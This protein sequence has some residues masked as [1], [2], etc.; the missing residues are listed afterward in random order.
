MEQV[1]QVQ[2]SQAIVTNE[3]LKCDAALS[4]AR[5]ND[6]IRW[7]NR[8]ASFAVLCELCV[9]RI[10]LS[11]ADSLRKAR[12]VPQSSRRRVVP[13]EGRPYMTTSLNCS[14]STRRG[15]QANA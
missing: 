12:K 11:L 3:H 15:S 1:S 14:C 6:P 4:H 10:S 7:R 9:Q 2:G 5:I 8:F 13:T